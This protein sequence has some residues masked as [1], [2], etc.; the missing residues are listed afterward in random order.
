MF[1]G[2]AVVTVLLLLACLRV[3]RLPV[4]MGERPTGQIGKMIF[5]PSWLI[6]A[7]CS[8]LIWTAASGSITFLGVTIKSMGGGDSLIGL[9]ATIAAVAEIPFMFFSGRM[10]RR[11]GMQRMLWVS[12]FFFTLRIGLY[13]FMPVPAWAIG[14]NLINGPSYVF[15]WNSAVNYANQM[16]PDSLKATA[17]GLFQSTTNLAS[18]VSALDLR[19]DVR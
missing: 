14:I 8:F 18:V 5:R 19:L 17:Q 11:M 1:P 4:R 3:P 2:Y 12:M 9:A 7:L 16:A 15:F 10:M 6:F 13:G